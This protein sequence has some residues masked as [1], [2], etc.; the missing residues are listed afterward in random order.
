MMKRVEKIAKFLLKFCQLN[1]AVTPL[2][3][4]S[5]AATRADG[6]ERLDSQ[7]LSLHGTHPVRE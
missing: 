4:P 1:K 2:R 6:S 5:A 7:E 3:R